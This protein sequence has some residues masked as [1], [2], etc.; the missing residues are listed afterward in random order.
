MYKL[1]LLSV[2]VCGCC[3]FVVYFCFGVFWGVLCVLINII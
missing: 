3:L 1:L 2:V